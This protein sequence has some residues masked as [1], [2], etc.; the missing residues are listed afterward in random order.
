LTT[1]GIIGCGYWG[2]NL[3]RNFSGL[4]GV[5]VKYVS[6]L[7]PGRLQFISE[8]YPDVI[9][10]EDYSAVLD[11]AEVDAVVVA[12]P[13]TTHRQIAELAFG[14]GKHV[15]VEKPM[16]HT[17]ED[18]WAMVE[19]AR[20]AGKVLAVG[21]IFQ[22]AP[23]VRKLREQIESGSLGKV[24]HL[25]STRINLGP[26][27]TTVD[28]VWD[29]APHDLSIILH[30]LDEMPTEVVAR[31]GSY[32][33]EGWIDNAHVDMR[34]PSGATA[35]LY[36]S[37][38][39]A[40]KTRLTQVFCEYGSMIY[41]EMLALDGKVKLYGRGVDNRVNAKDTDAVQLSYSAGE[42]HVLPLEQHEPLRMECAE[43]IRAVTTGS[44][45][46][47]NG[48]IGARVVELLEWI[49]R[50]IAAADPVSLSGALLSDPAGEGR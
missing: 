14:A 19:M 16:A 15:F 13:V 40:N 26:P 43:F 9:T 25:T 46:P 34:F 29:L 20:E 2:P 12:T 21:H 49:S 41:D 30:L 8:N 11:D 33:W 47:N 27:K 48:T 4:P 50:E 38:L 35:H 45:I 7:R 17:A 44:S 24:F 23:G 3:V 10:T 28:V 1:V 37:W 36:V 18:A 39:S 31:G 32:Q 22:F 42:I 6:D 5:R